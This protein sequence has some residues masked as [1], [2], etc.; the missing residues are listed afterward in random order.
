[1]VKQRKTIQ[2]ETLKKE[3]EKI[4]TFFTAHDLLL[5]IQKKDR[6]FGIATVY[7]FLKEACD[8]RELFSYVCDR[9]KVFSRADRSHCHFICERTGRVIHFDIDSLDFLKDRIPGSI[10]SFQIEVRGECKGEC[11][12]CQGR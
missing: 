5:R 10:S 12:R 3:L 1:M 7:R 2:K 9:K 8:R 11:S 4:D 6:H